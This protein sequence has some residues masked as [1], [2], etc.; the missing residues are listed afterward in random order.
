MSVC[1]SETCVPGDQTKIE[2]V[3]LIL[4]YV[5]TVAIAHNEAL[6]SLPYLFSYHCYK[7]KRDEIS[8]PGSCSYE[9]DF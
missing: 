3:D 5:C 8:L 4:Q 2:N 6:Y 7:H 9:Y 1:V